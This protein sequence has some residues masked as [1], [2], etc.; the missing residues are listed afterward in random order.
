[1]FL[2]LSLVQ[3][4]TVTDIAWH[5]HGVA[6]STEQ[7]VV[8]KQVVGLR[9]D[10]DKAWLERYDHHLEPLWSVDLELPVSVAK[11]HGRVEFPVIQTAGVVVVIVPMVDSLAA[12]VHDPETGERLQTRRLAEYASVTQIELLV[13]ESAIALLQGDTAT[14]WGHDL[15]E[16]GERS[17]SG[18]WRSLDGDQ[19]VR[20]WESGGVVT[21]ARGGRR[22]QL[23]APQGLVS[24]TLS[25][26]DGR[27]WLVGAL[28]G[29][30]RLWAAYVDFDTESLV[31]SASL[32][33]PGGR[34]KLL[35]LYP[36]EQGLIAVSEAGED[37]L[38]V[39]LMGSEGWAWSTGL[40]GS[41]PATLIDGGLLYDGRLRELDL[42]TGALG[43]DKPVV[44]E[45]LG[46][47]QSVAQIGQRL[48][49]TTHRDLMLAVDLS[50]LPPAPGGM[51]G[52]TAPKTASRAYLAGR[53]LGEQQDGQHPGAAL[54]GFAAA[55]VPSAA[56]G[57]GVGLGVGLAG[58]GVAA[59]VGARWAPHPPPSR[60][61]HLPPDFQQG[62][63]DAYDESVRRRQ[64]GWVVAGSGVGL[65][66]GMLVGS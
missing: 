66:T 56:V 30:E 15:E 3:A 65:L 14:V 49:I 36:R 58:A 37:E 25:C 17:S 53:K 13:G 31:W 39:A 55:A 16:L 28:R 47:V 33:T 52:T 63:I 45:E 57:G 44:P 12:L 18:A 42:E 43:H 21:L 29:Q 9:V 7:V 10:G 27:A 62:Y 24:A 48:L 35:E 61:S 2:L 26:Q 32:N 38:F 54:A 6:R 59:V 40:S 34:P 23:E 22:V 51:G 64:L 5:G 60:W 20:A 1:M 46:V 8:D 50:Q 19:V 11:R 4:Q 41:G